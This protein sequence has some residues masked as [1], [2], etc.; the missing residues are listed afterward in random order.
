[1]G[2]KPHELPLAG[3]RGQ[4]A[5]G[6][7]RTR[8]LALALCCMFLPAA[9]RLSPLVSCAAFLLPELHMQLCSVWVR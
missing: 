8:T 7:V 6:A 2:S 9:V 3:G 5:A 1:M 4:H